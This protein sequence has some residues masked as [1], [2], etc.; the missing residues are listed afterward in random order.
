MRGNCEGKAHIHAGTVPLDRSVEKFVDLCKSYDL[1]EL[2]FYFSFGHSEDRPVQ[3]N[4]LSSTQ[5]RVKTSPN[6]QKRGD[7]ATDSD[8]STCGLGDATE[9]LEQ[10]AFTRPITAD[11]ADHFTWLYG[12]GNVFQ[13]PEFGAIVRRVGRVADRVLAPKALKELPQL[14]PQR[15]GVEL[16]EPVT[17]RDVFD[18]DDGTGHRDLKGRSLQAGVAYTVSTNVFSILLK[19]RTPESSNSSVIVTETAR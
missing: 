7:S 11:D 16:P 12:K 9:N 6:L 17:L 5:V 8:L 15:H 14:L 2:C 19:T 3:I 4:I 18:F 10:R 1:I 13:R